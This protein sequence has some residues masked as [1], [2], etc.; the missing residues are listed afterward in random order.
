MANIQWSLGRHYFNEKACTLDFKNWILILETF[1]LNIFGFF[2]TKME[3]IGFPNTPIWK[4]CAIPK[5]VVCNVV[6]PKDYGPI[7]IAL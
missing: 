2:W 6:V 1:N 3:F 4:P 7:A 5:I